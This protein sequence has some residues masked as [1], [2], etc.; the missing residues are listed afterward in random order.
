MGARIRSAAPVPEPVPRPIAGEAAAVASGVVEPADAR[1]AGEGSALER[2]ETNVYE[3]EHSLADMRARYAEMKANGEVDDR[4]REEFTQLETEAIAAI[5]ETRSMLGREASG[6]VLL[7]AKLTQEQVERELATAME[8]RRGGFSREEMERLGSG[9]RRTVRFLGRALGG[10]FGM[11]SG[12][13]LG[14]TVAESLGASIFGLNALAVSIGLTTPLAQAGAIAAVGV[15][16]ASVVG[17]LITRR[18]MHATTAK[19]VFDKLSHGKNA[20]KIND[21]LV[22]QAANTVRDDCH[23]ELQKMIRHA[24]GG[25]AR[26]IARG[27]G[28][29]CGPEVVGAAGATIGAGIKEMNDTA[30]V[31][32]FNLYSGEEFLK[33]AGAQMQQTAGA[34]WSF[35][36]QAG[37][38][39]TNF[40]R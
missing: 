29:F 37:M 23:R 2:Y 7:Q 19:H 24:Y 21:V 36:K 1:R 6:Q 20:E 39:I 33:L 27:I 9:P 16:A 38:Y 8:K 32:P 35:A 22:R 10:A 12:A 25:R 28:R 30:T 26:R 34:G 4:L 17:Y 13:A 31:L 3:L 40:L 18:G 15:F 14:K 5:T 11:T